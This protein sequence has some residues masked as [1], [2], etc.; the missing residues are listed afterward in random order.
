[1][2]AVRPSMTVEQR[3][4]TDLPKAHSHQH[5]ELRFSAV[6]SCLETILG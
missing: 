1:M 6:F 2:A 4:H 3:Y 5:L